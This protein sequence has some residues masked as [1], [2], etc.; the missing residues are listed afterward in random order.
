MFLTFQSHT[1]YS[2]PFISLPMELKKINTFL[3]TSFYV[4]KTVWSP[5]YS[6]T[7]DLRPD[8]G[9]V[10]VQ[11]HILKGF[12]GTG[13]GPALMQRVLG[14]I[15]TVFHTQMDPRGKSLYL[16]INIVRYQ[17]NFVVLSCKFVIY[18]HEWPATN[19]WVHL[20][21]EG[22]IKWSSDCINFGL[23]WKFRAQWEQRSDCGMITS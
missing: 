13:S 5:Q 15:S 1:F 3:S 2:V 9:H 17:S 20:W 18:A 21:T 10:Q 19:K 8:P 16:T 12:I 7:E 23:R 11:V 14:L 4:F 6:Q 22:G